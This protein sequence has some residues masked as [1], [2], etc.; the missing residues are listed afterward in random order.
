MQPS[1]VKTTTNFG[2]KAILIFTA[3]KYSGN[4]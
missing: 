1:L 2:M 3:W 4:K